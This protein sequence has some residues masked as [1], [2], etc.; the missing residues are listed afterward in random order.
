MHDAIYQ[1]HSPAGKLREI[2][3]YDFENKLENIED[4]ESVAEFISSE[5]YNKACQD[6]IEKDRMLIDI[7]DPDYKVREVLYTKI[8][9]YGGYGF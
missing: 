2:K 1:L 4:I 5:H 9:I 3:L 8:I 7:D 6:N